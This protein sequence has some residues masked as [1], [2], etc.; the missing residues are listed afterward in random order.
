MTSVTVESIPEFRP[1]T[2]TEPEALARI[3]EP[4]DLTRIVGEAAMPDMGMAQV[5]SETGISTTEFTLPVTD[6]SGANER[7]LGSRKVAIVAAAGMLL[8][9]SAGCNIGGGESVVVINC[10]NGNDSPTTKINPPGRFKADTDDGKRVDLGWYKRKGDK[11]L[12]SNNKAGPYTEVKSWTVGG[13]TVD[14]HG[15]DRPTVTC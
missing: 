9:S 6:K 13:A 2:L 8:L 3:P 15:E 12:H 14:A 10:D 1:F 4:L 7:R 5:P 11:L